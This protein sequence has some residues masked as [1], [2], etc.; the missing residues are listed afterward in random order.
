MSLYLIMG[1]KVL[2]TALG[3]AGQVLGVVLCYLS[4]GHLLKALQAAGHSEHQIFMELP[5]SLL[6]LSE[7]KND[8]GWLMNSKR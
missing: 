3:Q 1:E 5:L 4:L 8:F 6:F 7:V 2:R